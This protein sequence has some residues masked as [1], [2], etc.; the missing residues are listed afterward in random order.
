M[1][2]PLSL[3]PLPAS[4]QSARERPGAGARAQKGASGATS[5]LYQAWAK[6]FLNK[7]YRIRATSAGL[8]KRLVH[9]A[10][11]LK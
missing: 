6:L 11:A 3:S 7:D 5:Y 2:C 10:M 9:V 8:L 4:F 1:Y